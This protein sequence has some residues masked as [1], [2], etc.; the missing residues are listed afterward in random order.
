MYAHS[1]GRFIWIK[2][3]FFF[4]QR[5]YKLFIL[6][7]GNE[8]LSSG[9]LGKSSPIA[10][11]NVTGAWPDT[12][13]LLW[14]KRLVRNSE[15]VMWSPNIFSHLRQP[16]GPDPGLGQ[17]STGIPL[18]A[19]QEVW[20]TWKYLMAIQIRGHTH[21]SCCK[22]FSSATV[23]PARSFHSGI[24]VSLTSWDEYHGN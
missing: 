5:F 17:T 14:L 13:V 4:S 11:T 21:P 8:S 2:Q 1:D 22:H 15:C 9:R 7:Q 12:T 23:L 19:V 16:H 24:T 3:D 18:R 20:D 6:Q 10:I